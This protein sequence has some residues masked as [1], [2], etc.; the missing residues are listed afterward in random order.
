MAQYKQVNTVLNKLMAQYRGGAG[1]PA[2]LTGLISLGRDNISSANFKDGYTH[3]LSDMV[4]KTVYRYLKSSLLFPEL[5]RNEFEWG[6]MLRK[7][8]IAPNQMKENE[9][10]KIGENGYTPNPFAINKPSF[11]EK[12]FTDF[13]AWSDIVTIPDTLMKTSFHS[14]EEYGA[15]IEAFMDSIGDNFTAHE[16]LMAKTCLTN[17]IA[18][19]IKHNNGVIDVLALY[20]SEFSTSLTPDVAIKTQAFLQYAGMVIRNIIKYLHNDNTIYN[21]DG[22]V[23]NTPDEEMLVYMLS[24]FV[25]A[26]NTYLLNGVSIFQNELINLPNYREVESWQVSGTWSGGAF[27]TFAGNSKI[28]MVPSDGGDPIN[29]EGI[30]GIIADRRGI[31]TTSTDIYVTTDR[32]NGARYT[33]Y[34]YGATNQYIND[35]SEQ[36]VVIIM[37]GSSSRTKTV[38]K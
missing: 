38:K 3:D 37:D 13:D 27:P 2:D 20:N 19:K 21:V 26:Y 22:S 7:I 14:A 8:R 15:F 31:G 30:I 29:Q 1:D 18:E 10:V 24:D 12:F 32:Y 5:S 35:L 11:T 33:N 34:T 4:G 36:G 23:N 28:V 6:G 25:S 17:W 9:S 16:N